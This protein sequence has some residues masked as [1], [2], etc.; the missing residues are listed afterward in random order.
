MSL[1]N[2]SG[3]GS[4]ILLDS[5]MLT[6]CKQ[7]K[8]TDPELRGSSSFPDS[9]IFLIPDFRR[10]VLGGVGGQKEVVGERRSGIGEGSVTSVEGSPRRP[11][12]EQQWD[13]GQ[14]SLSPQASVS[15][16]AHWGG[17]WLALSP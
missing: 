3:E 6:T 10:G 13:D 7:L 12:L 16:S 9:M 8:I 4:E 14:G 11:C 2:L 5:Q 17:N 15:L 1:F